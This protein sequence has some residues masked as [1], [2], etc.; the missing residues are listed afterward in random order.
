[1]LS[2]G[3]NY[4]WI[5]LGLLFEQVARS[6]LGEAKDIREVGVLVAGEFRDVPLGNLSQGQ[7]LL[8]L[9][10]ILSTLSLPRVV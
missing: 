8:H 1:M 9:L 10:Q 7:L 3:V 6:H 4:D 5:L 2:D